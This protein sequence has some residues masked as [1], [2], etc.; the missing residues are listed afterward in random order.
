MILVAPS[1]VIST[2]SMDAAYLS[3]YTALSENANNV[4][5]ITTGQSPCGMAVSDNILYVSNYKASSLSVIDESVSKVISNITVPGVPCALAIDPKMNAVYVI[6]EGGHEIYSIDQATHAVVG[7]FNVDLPYEMVVIPDTDTLY[8]TSD[9]IDKVYAIDLTTNQT[10]AS[11]DIPDPCGITANPEGNIVYVSSE[12]TGQVHKIDALTNKLIDSVPVG[13]GPR[14]MAFNPE[15]N[16]LFVANTG[17]DSVS[18]IDG[19]SNKVISTIGVDKAPKRIA[20]NPNTNIAYVISGQN[21][22]NFLDAST[23]SVIASVPVQN[24]YEVVVD[25]DKNLV[26]VSSLDSDFVYVIRGYELQS[27]SLLASFPVIMAM[28]GIA[29]GAGILAVLWRIRR[30]RTQQGADSAHD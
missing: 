2:T 7:K 8:V 20:V 26:Y 28:V 15:T 3:G 24:P 21:T 16:T 17:S 18:V 13:Q 29:A 23:N 30:L 12:S 27:S 11:F 25:S 9:A 10:V 19:A 22:L 5:R 1:L 6:N 4:D 14:G